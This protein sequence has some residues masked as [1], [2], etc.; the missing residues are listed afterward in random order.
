MSVHKRL[1]KEKCFPSCFR[2]EIINVDT[3]YRH[4]IH[5]I[6]LNLFT[7]E[8]GLNLRF[9]DHGVGISFIVANNDNHD[10]GISFVVANNY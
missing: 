10:V 9:H 6:W 5:I 1:K 2:V 8:G 4:Y 3:Y 7:L